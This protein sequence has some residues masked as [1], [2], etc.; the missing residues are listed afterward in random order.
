[1]RNV[2]NANRTLLPAQP[3]KA[4]ALLT[5]EASGVGILKSHVRIAKGLA[6]FVPNMETI[7]AEKSLTLNISL[8]TYALCSHFLSLAEVR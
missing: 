1:M 5:K 6:S 8:C 3:V 2:A 4:K 7:G